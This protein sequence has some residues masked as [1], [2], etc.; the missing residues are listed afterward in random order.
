MFRDYQYFGYYS[1]YYT[2]AFCQQ[3][4]HSPHILSYIPLS[5]SRILCE[6]HWV[7]SY[8]WFYTNLLILYLHY[9]STQNV[10]QAKETN[11]N[12]LGGLAPKQPLEF[13][14]PQYKSSWWHW[15]NN[16]ASP[17]H[18]LVMCNL[19]INFTA[20]KGKSDFTC[21]AHQ[22]SILIK[23]KSSSSLKRIRQCSI[24]PNTLHCNCPI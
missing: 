21:I 8:D 11:G 16:C 5:V 2:I 17:V 24:F 10:S 3:D 19:N 14:Y 6:E 23:L 13:W 20:I 9:H 22:D 15:N 4:R 18:S 12:S 7:N 1:R